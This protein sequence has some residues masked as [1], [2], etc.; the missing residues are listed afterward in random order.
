MKKN[1]YYLFSLLFISM[2]LFSCEATQEV[3]PTENNTPKL[4]SKENASTLSSSPRSFTLN[5]TGGD[6]AVGIINRFHNPPTITIVSPSMCP[7]PYYYEIPDNV[8]PNIFDIEIIAT[9]SSMRHIVGFCDDYGCYSHA[10]T[11]HYGL[12]GSNI[13]QNITALFDPTNW[14]P[15]PLP[16]GVDEEGG[17]GEIPTQP[18]Y[19]DV[20]I[21]VEAPNINVTID[22]INRY[23]TFVQ[24]AIAGVTILS[25]IKASYGVNLDLYN[26][27][28]GY[29]KV[30]FYDGKS[31]S[32]ALIAPFS[33]IT[34]KIV[35]TSANYYYRIY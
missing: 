1:F 6:Y 24:T 4:L 2:F 26:A 7:Y 11:Y 20:S 19:A 30:H 23:D 28:S 34:H 31:T 22:Y 3:T 14:R 35:P 17:S 8:T 15:D 33:S 9:N 10:D 27:N 5:I 25:Q 12:F 13:P 16:P 29:T 32:D 21:T 18:E